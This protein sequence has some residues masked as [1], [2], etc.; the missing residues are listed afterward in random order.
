MTVISLSRLRVDNALVLANETH[1]DKDAQGLVTLRKFSMFTGDLS[2]WSGELWRF[3]AGLGQRGTYLLVIE[4][5]AAW[6][7]HGHLLT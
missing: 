2:Q 5:N 1:K 6:L 3:C 7:G 4:M